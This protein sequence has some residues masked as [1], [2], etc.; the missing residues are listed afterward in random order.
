MGANRVDSGFVS[1]FIFTYAGVMGYGAA[2]ATGL[3]FVCFVVIN[4]HVLPANR[5]DSDLVCFK[6]ISF[7]LPH[8][9]SNSPI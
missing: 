7:H 2:E 6:K 8:C 9:F 3:A 1:F 5:V 4:R